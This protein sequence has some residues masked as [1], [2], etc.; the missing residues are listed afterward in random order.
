[1]EE[2]LESGQLVGLVI[3]QWHAVAVAVADAL[4]LADY[5]ENVSIVT[6]EFSKE[7]KPY[8]LEG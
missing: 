4:E 1:M 3:C 5:R 8:I 2:F 7:L 6:L